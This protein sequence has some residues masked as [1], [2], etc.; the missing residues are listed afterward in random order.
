MSLWY[1][2]FMYHILTL[3]W[4][5]YRIWHC[6]FCNSA[7]ELDIT[8][9]D[10]RNTKIGMSHIFS[11]FCCEKYETKMKFLYFFLTYKLNNW[12]LKSHYNIEYTRPTYIINWAP[13][14]LHKLVLCSFIVFVPVW[15]LN[16][17]RASTW[18]ETDR[19]IN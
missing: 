9:T 12:G 18:Q 14:H 11:Y 16:P 19:T 1:A 2:F 5:W 4:Y 15:C 13:D 3:K 6:K 10:K 17:I 8:Y 7:T